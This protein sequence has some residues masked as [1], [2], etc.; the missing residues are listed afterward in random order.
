MVGCIHD[1]SGRHIG[2]LQIKARICYARICAHSGNKWDLPITDPD[3][4][5]IIRELFLDIIL[6]KE[7][8][9]PH[10]PCWVSEFSQLTDIILPYDG[11]IEAYGAAAYA[12]CVQH[13]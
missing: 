3:L 6:V 1:L 9:K 12:L 4:V 10:Y 7:Q 13:E 5:E 11:G 8:L 2:P